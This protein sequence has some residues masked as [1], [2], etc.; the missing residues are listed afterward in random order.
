[1]KTVLRIYLDGHTG[2]PQLTIG[3]E[4]GDCYRLM[5]PTLIGNSKCLLA[6][7]LTVRDAREIRNHL[8]RADQRTNK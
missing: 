7:T 6:K 1:M 4:A 3:D 2:A 8:N 5:G